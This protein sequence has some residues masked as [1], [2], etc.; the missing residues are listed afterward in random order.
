MCARNFTGCLR[1]KEA[2]NHNHI[3][4]S[5]L[6]DSAPADRVTRSP[7]PP[8]KVPPQLAAMT[9]RA[10]SPDTMSPDTHDMN[11]ASTEPQQG[12]ELKRRGSAPS[13]LDLS[14]SLAGMKPETNIDVVPDGDA[15]LV[16]SSVNGSTKP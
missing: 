5:L 4:A 14:A 6:G 10:R 1:V 12:R 13:P 7:P 9:K 2:A 11:G 8:T 15:L 16:V 3:P